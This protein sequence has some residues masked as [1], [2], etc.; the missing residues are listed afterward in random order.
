M[1]FS[2]FL[3]TTWLPLTPVRKHDPEMR[4]KKDNLQ[5]LILPVDNCGFV[6]KLSPGIALAKKRMAVMLNP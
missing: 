2:L 3:S 1:T 6:P 5:D 4:A